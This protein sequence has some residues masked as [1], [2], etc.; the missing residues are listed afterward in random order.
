M[1]RACLAVCVVG[2]AVGVAAQWWAYDQDQLLLWLP[3]LVTGLTMIIAG[4]AAATRAR[5]AGLL[6]VATGFAWFAGTVVPAAT[7]WHRGLLI[8]LLVTYPGGRPASRFGWLLVS[9]GYVVAV[10]TPLWRNES[11]SIGVAAAGLCL[12]AV[13]IRTA[14]ARRQRTRQIAAR[15]GAALTVVLIAGGVARLVVPAGAAALPSLL[16]YEAALVV[17]AV[18]LM[19]GLRPAGATAVTDLVVELGE[20]R[21]A[22]LRGALADV[23]GDPT[24]RLGYWEASIAGYVDSGGNTLVFPEPGEDRVMTRI[25]REG[26]PFA[27]LVHDAALAT[28]SRF[29]DAFAAA[30]Q[31]TSVHAALQAGIQAH[32]DEMSASRRRLQ[33]ALDE[34]RHRLERRLAA[35]P[36]SHLA[37][38]LAELRGLGGGDG[39]HLDRAADQLEQTLVELRDAAAGLYPRELSGGLSA[40]LIALANRC[41]VPVDLVATD[42]RFDPAV[43]VAAYYLCAEALANVAKHAQACTASISVSARSGV[44]IVTVADD[45]IGAASVVGG[46]GIRG[47]IDRVESI[48]G[49]L[50]L[51]SATGAGTT[52]TAEIPLDGQPV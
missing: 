11:T 37:E 36:E 21:S 25:E 16:G 19:I 13:A 27:A 8:H 20:N 42:Q 46:T 7:Y 17:A 34:E 45:G 24:L 9:A 41:P 3:D 51:E 52:L 43:E 1:R 14:T 26:Q 38:M 35:A 4:A 47:L 18:A 10:A 33:M 29:S 6:L 50:A 23:L 32:L 15:V 22:T 12:S 2:V 49:T 5:G 30:D 40:G 39:T 44:L 31:L 28:D 48:G